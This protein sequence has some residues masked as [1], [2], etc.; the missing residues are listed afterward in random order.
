MIDRYK[1]I[2]DRKYDELVTRPFEKSMS[3]FNTIVINK[4]KKLNLTFSSIDPRDNYKKLKQAEE[5]MV[6]MAGI[7]DDVFD[8]AERRARE[9]DEEDEQMN[10]ENEWEDEHG[11]DEEV[12]W[13]E[14]DYEENDENIINLMT[15]YM[16]D[17]AKNSGIKNLENVV[18]NIVNDANRGSSYAQE[19]IDKVYS[20]I[21]RISS[22]FTEILDERKKFEKSYYKIFQK[23]QRVAFKDAFGYANLLEDWQE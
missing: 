16:S 1:S 13:S 18:D 21:S 15:L 23:N 9:G 4:Y 7:V 14:F 6:E 8:D 12:D 5:N 17:L 10:F 2:F 19:F 11:E 22:Q 3:V 20:D